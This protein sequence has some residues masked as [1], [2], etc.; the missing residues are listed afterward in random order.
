MTQP[1]NYT[2]DSAVGVDF[3]QVYTVSASATPET[4]APPFLIGTTLIGF[5][6]AEYIFVQ[7]STS[8]SAN[9]FIAITGANQANSLTNTNVEA[10]GGVRIGVAPGA[11][12]VTSTGIAAQAYF[13]A[14][15]NGSQLAANGVAASTTSNVQLYTTAVAGVV[16]SV[17]GS[18]GVPLGG[19][20]LTA[21]ATANPQTFELSWPRLVAIINTSVQYVGPF[22]GVN[23]MNP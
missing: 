23:A 21:S 12:V 15:L 5:F 8:I 9:D 17:T 13:W 11:P 18:S 16:S 22:F 4:P 1:T 19:V 7:A 6:G 2:T 10:T 20:I 3:N 14:A